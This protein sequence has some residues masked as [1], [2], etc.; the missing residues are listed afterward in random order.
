MGTAKNLGF[1]VVGTGPWANAQ[2]T[3]GGVDLREIE[4]LAMESRLVKGLYFAGEIMDVCGD[5]GGYNLHWA[6]VSGARA[7]EAMAGRG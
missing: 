7:G 4:P 3:R 6:W 1:T 5:C 2:T